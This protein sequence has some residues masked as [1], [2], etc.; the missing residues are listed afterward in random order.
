MKIKKKHRA[1]TAVAAF[2][3]AEEAEAKRLVSELAGNSHD[4]DKI[5]AI[6]NRHRE[7]L[8]LRFVRI[9]TL[10][11][12]FMTMDILESMVQVVDVINPSVRSKLQ[13]MATEAEFK[14]LTGQL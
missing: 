11:L 3:K 1:A 12:V 7:Q 4:P 9:T 13:G 6:M 8:G 14:S 10:A 2:T 5:Y